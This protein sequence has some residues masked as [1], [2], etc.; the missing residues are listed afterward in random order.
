MNYAKAFRTIRASRGASQRQFAELL[1]V[2][3]S[4][5]SRIEAGERVP[6]TQILEEISS[7]FAVPLYLMMLLA[8]EESDLKDIPAKEA[9]KLGKDLLKL[10]VIHKEK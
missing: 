4:Y 5:I 8:S 7:R 3:P 1:K 10:L 9:E 6:S 2:D